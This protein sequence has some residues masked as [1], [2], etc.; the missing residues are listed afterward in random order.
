[1]LKNQRYIQAISE[2]LLP[3]IG[4]FFFDWGLYFILL[5]Y[6]IDL[7]VTEFFVFLKAQKIHH[8]QP[9]TKEKTNWYKLGALSFLL[10]CL[11]ILST[12]LVLPTIIQGINFKE[13]L[14]AFHSYEEVGIPIQQGYIILP[15]VILGNYQ[16]YKMNFLM[17]AQYRF[18]SVSQLFIPRLTALLICI[19]GTGLAYVF[20]HILNLPEVVYLILIVLVKLVVDLRR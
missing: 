11:T 9:S 19:I 13:Q 1:M 8:H 3:L 20:A 4:F 5:Y 14:I 17:L 15:L 6:I 18:I 2:T 12:H 16:L 10:V 7:V